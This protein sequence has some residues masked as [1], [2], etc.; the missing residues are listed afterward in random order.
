MEESNSNTKVGKKAGFFAAYLGPITPEN[1]EKEI[2]QLAIAWY[3]VAGLQA[4]LSLFLIYVGKFPLENLLDPIA[5]A[6]GGY[7]LQSRKSRSVAAALFALALVELG[8]TI[9]AKIGMTDGGKNIWLAVI[10][11]FIGW[12]SIKATWLFQKIHNAKLNWK[13]VAGISA[14]VIA[15]GILL[16]VISIVGL[17]ITVPEPTDTMYGSALL[18]PLVVAVFAGTAILTKKYPLAVLGTE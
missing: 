9:A 15:L 12:R 11:V 13:R 18:V 16:S 2:R 10:V 17:V 7:F 5:L 14:A 8:V 4:A 6:C 1:V 3:S